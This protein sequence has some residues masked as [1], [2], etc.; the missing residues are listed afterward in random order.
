MIIAAFG[1]INVSPWELSTTLS[2]LNI[3]HTITS[4]HKAIDVD[5]LSAEQPAWPVILPL[6]DVAKFKATRNPTIL[7]VTGSRSA[8]AETNLNNCLWEH[9]DNIHTLDQTLRMILR[10]AHMHPTDWTYRRNA[11][12][13][14]DYVQIASKPSFLTLIQTAIYK[15]NPYATR[16]EVQN[17]C[18]A[19]LTG[20]VTKTKL[21]QTLKSNWKFETLLGI[22]ESDKA[23]ELKSAIERCTVLSDA[24]QVA[25]ETGFAQF[26]ITYCIRSAELAAQ[27]KANPSTVRRGRKPKATKT[28]S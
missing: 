14:Q 20:R 6:E 16:K 2:N 10:A 4:N 8:L 17:L 19:Y 13:I 7:F 21:R 15:I 23:S 1:V 25:K 27:A 18:I 24:E 11:L 22:M 28:Q 9:G 26:E 12:A 5:G 3:S